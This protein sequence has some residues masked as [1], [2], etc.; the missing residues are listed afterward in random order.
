MSVEI[1]DELSKNQ[2]LFVNAMLMN[3][4]NV[5]CKL[6]LI[7]I[8]PYLLNGTIDIYGVRSIV[9]YIYIWNARPD[10]FTSLIYRIANEL[11][12]LVCMPHA[13]VNHSPPQ[14]SRVVNFC[15]ALRISTL[16]PVS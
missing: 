12:R 9:P 2:I 6:S 11:Y 10:T 13:E 3:D 5:K 14:F 15:L 16:G 7:S 1:I 8:F 4:V